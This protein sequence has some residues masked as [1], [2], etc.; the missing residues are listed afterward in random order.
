MKKLLITL[1]LL[2]S[3]TSVYASDFQWSR[4]YHNRLNIFVRTTKLPPGQYIIGV[5]STGN[6]IT[7]YEEPQAI[8]ITKEVPIDKEV[9][10][11]ITIEK[12]IVDP[13]VTTGSY[14]LS[15]RDVQF[16][17]DCNKLWNQ[18]HFN[19][20]IADYIRYNTPLIPI[21]TS[22]RPGSEC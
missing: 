16:L 6:T 11:Y 4:L 8:Q 1:L 19:S 5:Y 17:K 7:Q 3:F 21:N 2:T 9:I 10:R 14:I 15:E 22:C 18:S 13:R 20:C 12:Q